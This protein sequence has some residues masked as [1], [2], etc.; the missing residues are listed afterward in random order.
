MAEM[1]S[2][3]LHRMDSLLL[4]L[5]HAEED[6]HNPAYSTAATPVITPAQSPGR[7]WR[8]ADDARAAAERGSN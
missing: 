8:G 7:S 5:W 4:D 1:A 3:R 2:V 6:H